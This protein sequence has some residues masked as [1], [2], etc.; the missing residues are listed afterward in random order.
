MRLKGRRVLIVGVSKGLGYALA[1]FLLKEGASVIIN[2]RN[3]EKL[4]EIKKSLES[5]GEIT[6]VVGDVSTLEKAREVVEKAGNFTDLVVTVGG[7]I[8]DTVEDLKGLD[9][10]INSH[11]K[12][13]LYV[14]HSSLNKLKEGS[15]IVLVSAIR[16]IYTAY[17]TQLSYAVGKAGLA[18]EVEILASELLS[19][20]IRVVGIAPSFIDGDFVP[21]RDWKKLRKLG[22]FKA[23]PEDFARVIVWLLTEEAEWVNGV[24]IP[25]D[26][27][28]R[29]K[30]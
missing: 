13:P 14:I 10:M 28:A 7:Y 21:D 30:L 6:Y 17:P 15:T 20:G 11:I 3:E 16:G 8:E 23:P 1:Y 27:G 29:L 26:G 25:V 5:I 2:S 18:K 9:E 19:R 24:V 22:D 4:K 12:I